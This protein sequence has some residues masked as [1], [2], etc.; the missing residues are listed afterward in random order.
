MLH[1]TAYLWCSSS[2]LFHADHHG[3]LGC[4]YCFYLLSA[5]TWENKRYEMSDMPKLLHTHDTT[6]TLGIS[7]SLFQN[8]GVTWHELQ[9]CLIV[10]LETWTEVWVSFLQYQLK[11]Y[12][13]QWDCNKLEPQVSKDYLNSLKSS[14]TTIKMAHA[15]RL[16]R[17]LE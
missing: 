7:R 14:C 1:Y 11:T 3:W 8:D 10:R 9:H 4:N 6:A 13:R 16:Y 5:P 12:L 17:L 2:C 15:M